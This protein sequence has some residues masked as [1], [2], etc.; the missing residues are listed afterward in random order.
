[1][2]SSLST[3]PEDLKGKDRLIV[4]LDVPTAKEA[5]E[6]VEKL[7]NVSFFKIGWQLYLSGDIS[8]LLKR[9]YEKRI[10]IDL[11]IPGDIG[12]TISNLMI[13]CIRLNVKFLTLSESVPLAIIKVAKAARESGLSAYPKLLTVPFLSSMDA[14]DLAQIAPG[15]N[16]EDYILSRGQYLLDAGC[17][18]LIASGR[19]IK[20]CRD[21]FPNTL[22][23]SPGIRPAGV[24]FDDHKRHTTPSEA[25]K[26]GADYLV[27][28][29]PILQASDPKARADKIIVEI[30]EALDQ[31]KAPGLEATSRRD[32]Q[33]P[34]PSQV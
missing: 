29:R 19:E 28:G 30:D 23:V 9:L 11:K 12:N 8:E 10:F 16:L 18:G 20:L 15:K 25:I 24:S 22:I 14:T 4:A 6:I 33:Y 5:I 31:R 1:M 32:L 7:D 27:V 3:R 26:F 34:L 21:K 2:A 13:T 17:D